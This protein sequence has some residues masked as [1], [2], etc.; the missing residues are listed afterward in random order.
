MS[1]NNELLTE[2]RDSNI[3]SENKDTSGDNNDEEK[4]VIITTE[5]NEKKNYKSNILII[6]NFWIELLSKIAF[7]ASLIV[8]LYIAGCVSLTLLNTFEGNLNQTLEGI[9]NLIQKVGIKRLF[10][11]KVGQHLSIGFFCLSNISKFLNEINRPKKFF[12]YNFIQFIL[13]FLFSIFIMELG[14]KIF[15][16]EIK[17]INELND[18]STQTKE[19][20]LKIIDELKRFCQVLLGNMLG[21]I[22]NSLDRL[23][24]GGL[25][26]TLFLSPKRLSKKYIIFF[27]LL[28]VVP[29][30]YIVVGLII[31][32]LINS[33]KINWCPEI[34]QLFVGPKITIFCYYITFLLYVKIKGKNNNIFDK[35]NNI[36]PSAF[37]NISFRIFAFFGF[38]E[39]SVG[40]IFPW[41]SSIGIGNHYLFI[42]CTPIILLY[43]YKKEFKIHMNRC[44]ILNSPVFINIAVS[45]TSIIIIFFEG[46][47]LY[48]FG[49]VLI[50]QYLLPIYLMVAD[51]Y[52][53][54]IRAFDLINNSP[55]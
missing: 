30:S 45:L 24:I 16:K 33:K 32:A 18:V 46:L 50:K 40:L 34:S 15:D 42:L 22:S 41:I 14:I 6:S 43:D 1:I 49:F 20:L 4:E 37:S 38:I 7:Y 52:E 8:Y 54:I 48:M 28:S 27:R 25:Y 13:F 36:K 44:K 23:L 21:N 29:M 2:D 55:L 17:R 5:K 19:K 51:N 10:L 12:I 39:L 9:T 31:R 3:K 11:A 47:L 35:K 53:F 26:S